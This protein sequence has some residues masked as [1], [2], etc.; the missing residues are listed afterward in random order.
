MTET[1]DIYCI[2]SFTG[3]FDRAL[4]LSAELFM[5]QPAVVRFTG[6]SSFPLHGSRYR[7][8]MLILP[9]QLY[10]NHSS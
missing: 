7:L 2:S 1:R 4:L 9:R 8:Y 10:C 5:L 3:G 6:M